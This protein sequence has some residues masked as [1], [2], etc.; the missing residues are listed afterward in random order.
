MGVALAGALLPI[1]AG[2][3]TAAPE[4][5]GPV[6]HAAGASH[7]DSADHASGFTGFLRDAGSDD[8]HAVSR[9]G[10]EWLFSGGVAALAVHGATT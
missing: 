5:V 8:R 7:H 4:L 6:V 1:A 3:Q 9:G 10:A 2:A